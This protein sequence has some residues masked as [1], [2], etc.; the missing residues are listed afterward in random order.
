MNSVKQLSRNMISIRQNMV[1]RLQLFR[2]LQNKTVSV[3]EGENDVW[4]GVG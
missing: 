1:N 2:R 4:Q 3:K